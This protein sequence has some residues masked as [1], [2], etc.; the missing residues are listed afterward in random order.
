M[1][2]ITFGFIV[3]LFEEENLRELAPSLYK[4]EKKIIEKG[5]LKMP[6][7][8]IAEVKDIVSPEGVQ[9][10]GV[11]VTTWLFPEQY[12]TLPE[13]V[14]FKRILDA[15]RI[16][17]QAGAKIVGL[18]GY[19]SIVPVGAGLRIARNSRVGITNGNSYTIITSLEAIKQAVYK[20]GLKLSDLSVLVLGATGSIG[21][22]I[23][24]LMAMEKPGKL[25][26]AARNT[27]RLEG[28]AK[29]IFKNTGYQVCVSNNIENALQNAHVVISAT[30]S[31]GSV[32]NSIMPGTVVCDVAIPHDVSERIVWERDDVIVIN[33]G[34]AKVPGSRAK[35]KPDLAHLFGMQ[36]SEGFACFSETAILALDGQFG[37]FSLDRISINNVK[38]IWALSKKH[39]FEIATLRNQRE[40]PIP[41]SKFEEIGKLTKQLPIKLT[42]NP[43]CL[44]A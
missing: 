41:D 12:F 8:K 14:V 2:D 39:G 23:S 24:E 22:V 20:M 33:G 3:H 9:I 27:I 29:T 36:P 5:L 13:S 40:I 34:I 17:E 43:V 7:Q 21:S 25:T 30:S 38:E 26:L 31:P 11:L 35:L 18:G 1:A 44:S 32:I 37:N 10:N 16:A 15:V 19:N 28:R 6:P 42:D 4:K